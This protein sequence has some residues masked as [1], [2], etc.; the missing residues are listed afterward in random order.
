MGYEK[1]YAR[2]LTIISNADSRTTRLRTIGGAVVDN[3]EEEDESDDSVSDDEIV[4][5]SEVD[6]FVSTEIIENRPETG[7]SGL[8]HLNGFDRAF[9][10]DGL[11]LPRGWMTEQVWLRSQDSLG[12]GNAGI[13]TYTGNRNSYGVHQLAGMRPAVHLSISELINGN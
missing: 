1:E 3:I 10:R 7:R 6:G 8:W 13:V 11:G 2:G 9:D 12:I 4:D 5:T